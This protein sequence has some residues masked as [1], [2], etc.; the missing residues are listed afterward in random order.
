MFLHLNHVV[1]VITKQVST[2]WIIF[3]ALG[4]ITFLSRRSNSFDIQGG[5]FF[6]MGRGQTVATFKLE[7][8][9]YQSEIRYRTSIN[10]QG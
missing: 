7:A 5:C 2:A 1:T 10:V 6:L 8:S 3:L 4:S 9:L